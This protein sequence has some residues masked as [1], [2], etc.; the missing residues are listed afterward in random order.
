MSEIHDT[1]G[2][3][4][5]KKP[6]ATSILV[7]CWLEPGVEGGPAVRGYL[8]NLQTG[9]ET[10]I[11]DVSTVGTHILKQLREAARDASEPGQLCAVQGRS[12]R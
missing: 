6:P 9:E 10:L 7:R 11:G 4:G 1:I 5:W 12:A 2:S 3:G 8:R